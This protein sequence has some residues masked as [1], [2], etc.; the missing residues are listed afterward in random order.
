M[1]GYLLATS[2]YIFLEPFQSSTTESEMFNSSIY[3]QESPT[4]YFDFS[5]M[6]LNGYEGT[7]F[8]KLSHQ[9]MLHLNV[10]VISEEWKEIIL[11]EAKKENGNLDQ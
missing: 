3:D 9:M 4:E 7:T 10:S 11:D 5:K 6:M 1:P 2:G 8:E